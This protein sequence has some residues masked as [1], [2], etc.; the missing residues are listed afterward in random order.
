MDK[1]KEAFLEACQHAQIVTLWNGAPA[2]LIA[3]EVIEAK[4]I[5]SN[6][7][8]WLVEA[9][10]RSRLKMASLTAEAA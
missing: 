8:R 10:R 1:E 9:L 5:N 7:V 6:S 2:I 4:C 3:D